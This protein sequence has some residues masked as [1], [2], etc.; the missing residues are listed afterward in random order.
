MNT[1]FNRM[2]SRVER[3]SGFSLV[4][5]MVAM[6]VLSIGLIGVASL[7]LTGLRSNQNAFFRSQA[8]ILASDIIDRMRANPQGVLAGDYNNIDSSGTG[9]PADPGCINAGCDS[10]NLARHDIREWIGFFRNIDNDP[11]FA[12]VLPENSSGVVS[13]SVGNVFT[14]TVNWPEVTEEGLMNRNLEVN[15]RL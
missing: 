9:V 13:R 10:T 4:E 15:F 2:S 8:T 3:V 12:R 1:R 7:Q 11:N 14:V 6:L 5:V